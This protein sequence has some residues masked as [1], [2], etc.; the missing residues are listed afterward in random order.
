MPKLAFDS[1][2]ANAR[3][4][5]SFFRTTL[6]FLEYIEPQNFGKLLVQRW[7]EGTFHWIYP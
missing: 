7:S 6:G 5:S 3:Q 1:T 2:L 4:C